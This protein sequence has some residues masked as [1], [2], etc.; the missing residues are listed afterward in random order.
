MIHVK[1]YTIE[2]GAEGGSG[3][4]GK[5]EDRGMEVWGGMMGVKGAG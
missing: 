5:G 3:C 1:T 4:C 2:M